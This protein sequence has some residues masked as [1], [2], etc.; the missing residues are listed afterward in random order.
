MPDT[1]GWGEWSKHVL[2]ELERFG[3]QYDHLDNKI[4]EFQL[5]QTK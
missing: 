1:N 2:L 3:K 4:S 5:A